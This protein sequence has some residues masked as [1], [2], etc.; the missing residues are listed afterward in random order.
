MVSIFSI[1]FVG[2]GNRTHTEFSVQIRSHVNA[3]LNQ[4]RLISHCSIDFACRVQ[5]IKLSTYKFRYIKIQLKINLSTRLWGNNYRVCGVYAPEPQAEVYCVRLN[6][7]ISK[8]VYST[9]NQFH[10][11]F[12]LLI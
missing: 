11:F 10:S 12:F 7:N 5:S 8:L 9:S 4:L 2:L 6:F 1:E 3:E